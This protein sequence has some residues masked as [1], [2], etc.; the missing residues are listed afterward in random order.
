[1]AAVLRPDRH[2]PVARATSRSSWRPTSCRWSQNTQ[3]N[4]LRRVTGDG[5]IKLDPSIFSD[6]TLVQY[7]MHISPNVF[8]RDGVFGG[9]GGDLF[10]DLGPANWLG[11]WFTVRLDD[12]PVYAKLLESYIRS[13]MFPEERHDFVADLELAFQMPLTIGFDVR[14]PL[15]FA[16][17]LT[18]VRKTVENTLPG[19]LD[20][21][22]LDEPY[23]GV[24]IVRI[25]ASGERLGRM[26][27][28]PDGARGSIRPSTTPWSTAPS[29]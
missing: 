4:E 9:F 8:G 13:E 15:M 12:S 27:G 5:T 7:L 21:R 26:I 28:G 11:D 22:P 16:G 25:K 24:N 18:G 19:A 14:S 23:K 10:I 3:Y 29:T 6:K 17:L 1:M 2:A 20:W